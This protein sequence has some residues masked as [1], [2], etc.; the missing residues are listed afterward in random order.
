MALGAKVEPVAAL[1]SGILPY[2]SLGLDY[3][4]NTSTTAGTSAFISP[5]IG[6]GGGMG[7]GSG[8]LSVDLNA[9]K[10]QEGVRGL[11]LRATYEFSF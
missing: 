8:Y 5:R 9:G 1:A 3:G 6:V 7:I 4:T 10:V 11:G 2:V